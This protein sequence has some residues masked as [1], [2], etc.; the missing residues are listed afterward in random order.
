MRHD[1]KV[2]FF[3]QT[4]LRMVE[5]GFSLSFPVRIFVLF[6]PPV[7]Y[8]GDGSLYRQAGRLVDSGVD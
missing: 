7:W 3:L 4:A 5:V 6:F 8:C 1:V 2:A